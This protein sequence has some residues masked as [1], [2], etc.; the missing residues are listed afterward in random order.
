M[1]D[2]LV[3]GESNCSAI[4]RQFRRKNKHTIDKRHVKPA[5]FQK[6]HLQSINTGENAGELDEQLARS[7]HNQIR[8]SIRLNG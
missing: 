4:D 2:R 6:T 5:A 7:K 1:I 3:R 8:K